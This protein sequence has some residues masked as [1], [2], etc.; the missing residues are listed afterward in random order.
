MPAALL[1][2]VLSI[3]NFAEYPRLRSDTQAHYV[4]SYDRTGGN[5][6]G[7]DGTYSALYVDESGEHVIFDVK[8][9][10]MLYN[11][12]FTSRMNG[13][14]PLGWGRIKFYFDDEASPRI[15]MDVDDFITNV[16]RRRPSRR[17]TAAKTVAG[18]PG[19][20]PRCS[21]RRTRGHRARPLAECAASFHSHR[22]DRRPDGLGVARRKVW[23][24]RERTLLA[25]REIAEKRWIRIE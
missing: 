17:S 22:L 10:G 1:L 19:S 21:P 25:L 15:D 9:P 7:F 14:S 6:D 20:A 3:A 13:R 16:A 5:D 24:G 18:S 2:A 11:L 4:S 12:W 23:R 8:G